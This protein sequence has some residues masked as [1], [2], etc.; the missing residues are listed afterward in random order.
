LPS[1]VRNSRIKAAR[2]TDV[3]NGGLLFYLDKLKAVSP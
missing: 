3:R 1:L 2:P